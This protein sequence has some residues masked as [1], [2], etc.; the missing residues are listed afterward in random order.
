MNE[1]QAAQASEAASIDVVGIGGPADA[2]TKRFFASYFDAKTRHQAAEAAAF[3]T[4]TAVYEDEILPVEVRGRQALTDAW[5]AFLTNLPVGSGSR[6]RAV[7]GGGAGAVID[8]VDDPELFG[9]ELQALGL[10]DLEVAPSS[11][12]G[13]QIGRQVDYWNGRD[14]GVSNLHGLRS[15]LGVPATPPRDGRHYQSSVGHATPALDQVVRQLSAALGRGDGAAVAACFA[16]DGVYEDRTLGLRLAGRHSIESGLAPIVNR[17]PNGAGSTP[18]HLVGN[19]NGGGFD[20]VAAHDHAQ[21]VNRGLTAL[22]LRQG[23]IVELVNLWDA[24]GLT[25]KEYDTILGAG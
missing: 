3:F 23:E 4:P 18:H 11:P 20:W 21:T 19:D 24:S 13:H 2:D 7:Y 15:M 14:F 10:V 6:L 16:P 5:T 8:F 25:D 17:L 22:T 9:A 1:T 12:F